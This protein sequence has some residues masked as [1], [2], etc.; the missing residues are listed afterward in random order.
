LIGLYLALWLRRKTHSALAVEIYSVIGLAY[1]VV[2]LPLPRMFE[3]WIVS[4]FLAL[5][6][7]GAFIVRYRIIR[8]YSQREGIPFRINPLLTAFFSV[9]Y[10]SGCLRADFPLDGGGKVGKGVLR[11]NAS[12]GE[13]ST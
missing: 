1:L 9:W 3:D 6:I 12:A 8:Y 7:A 11:L 5:W 2:F 4:A 10:I 13:Q